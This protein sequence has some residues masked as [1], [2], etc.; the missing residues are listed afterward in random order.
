MK[1]IEMKVSELL[2]AFKDTRHPIVSAA[3]LLGIHPNAIRSWE[4]KDGLVPAQWA[5]LYREKAK[6][7]KK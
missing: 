5:A 6:E 4:K 2:K 7:A 3:S 1:G